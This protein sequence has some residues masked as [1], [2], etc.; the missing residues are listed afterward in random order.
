[1]DGK[2]NL[3]NVRSKATADNAQL[4]SIENKRERK[5]KLLPEEEAFLL[6]YKEK[7][8]KQQRSRL[9]P[10]LSLPPAPGTMGLTLELLARRKD[11]ALKTPHMRLVGRLDGFTR[12]TQ[13][14]ASRIKDALDERRKAEGPSPGDVLVSSN[15]IDEDGIDFLN[16]SVAKILE[17]LLFYIEPFISDK[18]LTHE[19]IDAVLT[20]WIQGVDSKA[21]LQLVGI[22][23]MHL[24][25]RLAM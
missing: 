18:T 4:K 11:R 14:N 8:E 13:F 1:M 7:Q 10:D 19:D 24:E 3:D 15:D 16:V 6:E 12:N 20:A 9:S 25:L 2:N 23:R 5:E 22:R 17:A 21:S